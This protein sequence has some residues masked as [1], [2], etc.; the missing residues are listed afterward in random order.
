MPSINEAQKLVTQLA[1]D[2]GF[3]TRLEDKL[4]WMVEEVGELMHAYKHGDMR[5]VAEEAVDVFF[6]VAAILEIIGADGDSVFEEKLRRNY[7]R[8]PVSEGEVQHFDK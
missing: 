7:E 6:F 4:I 2:K 1:L 5:E 3:S 8:T